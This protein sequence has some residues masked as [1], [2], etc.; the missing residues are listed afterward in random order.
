M[1]EPEIK[2]RGRKP[3]TDE[4]RLVAI[5]KNRERSLLRIK[6]LYQNDPE[7]R[8]KHKEK[9][10]AYYHKNRDLIKALKVSSS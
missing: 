1:I 5:Q 9:C 4:E 8:L 10:K 3:L 6:T 7:Y 2:K